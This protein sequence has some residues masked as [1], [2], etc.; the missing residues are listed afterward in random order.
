MDPGINIPVTHPLPNVVRIDKL[1]GNYGQ[2]LSNHLLLLSTV[3]ITEP[4]SKY[5][6]SDVIGFFKT[7]TP[8]KQD[9]LSEVFVLLRLLL[10]IPASNAVSE[11]AFSNLRRVKTC[12]RSTMNQDRLNHLMVVNIHRERTD[13]LSLIKTA[14]EFIFGNEPRLTVFGKFKS[15]VYLTK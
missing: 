12:L 15:T 10:V 8:A 5:A 13:T 7:S 4:A 6:L 14:N 9:L 3:F 11:R 2:P 1:I